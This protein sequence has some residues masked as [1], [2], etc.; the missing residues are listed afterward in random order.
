MRNI[1]MI[2]DYLVSKATANYILFPNSEAVFGMN[3]QY[4]EVGMDPSL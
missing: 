2:Q 4:R 1:Q 3:M